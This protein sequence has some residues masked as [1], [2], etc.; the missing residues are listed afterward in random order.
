MEIIR[1]LN[2]KFLIYYYPIYTIDTWFVPVINN[3]TPMFIC[4]L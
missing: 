4:Q 2:K 3:P 1:E